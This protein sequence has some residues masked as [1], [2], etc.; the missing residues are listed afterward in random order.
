MLEPRKRDHQRFLEQRD[1]AMRAFQELELGPIRRRDPAWR[2]AVARVWRDVFRRRRLAPHA[3]DR[4]LRA[5]T[6]VG[7]AL[8]LVLEDWEH[9]KIRRLSDALARHERR[10]RVDPMYRLECA[11]T[12]LAALD[13][14]SPE[15]RVPELLMPITEDVRNQVTREYHEAASAVYG[16]SGPS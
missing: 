7:V 1:G 15:G 13:R 9:R 5:R 3:V 4:C 16:G 14:M 6:M 12:M 2:D 8:K 11:V 10:R